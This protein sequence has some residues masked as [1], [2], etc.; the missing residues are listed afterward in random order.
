ML[1]GLACQRDIAAY[2]AHRLSSVHGETTSGVAEAPCQA[3]KQGREEG[4][5]VTDG[6]A[7]VGASEEGGGNALEEAGPDEVEEQR[8]RNIQA[9][10]RALLALVQDP[11]PPPRAWGRGVVRAYLP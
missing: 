5:R 9:G 7:A 11:I 8:H 4:G 10:R 6:G 3:R 2:D 1:S